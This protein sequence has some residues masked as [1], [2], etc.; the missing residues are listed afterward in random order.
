MAA[1]CGRAFTCYLDRAMTRGK[2]AAVPRWT[3][4]DESV[5]RNHSDWSVQ[6]QFCD[7]QCER[8]RGR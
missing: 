4:H 7:T 6:M 2:L 3:F 5:G 8:E 1:G